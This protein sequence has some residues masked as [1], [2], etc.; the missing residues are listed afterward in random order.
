MPTQVNPTHLQ[1]NHNLGILSFLN[2]LPSSHSTM[3]ASLPNS[4]IPKCPSL[5]EEQP[6][7]GF[8]AADSLLV[9]QACNQRPYLLLP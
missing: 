1:P 3:I 9:P 8:K 2:G 6:L 5:S 7:Q 4:G